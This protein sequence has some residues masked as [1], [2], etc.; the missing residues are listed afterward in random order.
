MGAKEGLPPYEVNRRTLGALLGVGALGMPLKANAAS[1]VLVAT[2]GKTPGPKAAWGVV[3]GNVQD[4]ISKDNLLRFYG[5]LG[6][7]IR[8]TPE[9]AIMTGKFPPGVAPDISSCEGLLLNYKASNILKAKPIGASG[10]ETGEEIT[11]TVDEY[12]GWYV[13]LGTRKGKFGGFGFG[14]KAKITP[15]LNEYGAVKVPF[16]EFT[17]GW[18]DLNFPGKTCQES[19]ENCLSAEILKDIKQIAFWAT[20]EGVYSLSVKDIS[21]YGCTAAPQLATFDGASDINL[22]PVSAVTALGLLAFVLVRIR[23]RRIVASPALLG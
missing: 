21:A 12:K 17:N 4:P 16:K 13:S 14:Y 5:S 10:K 8:G 15:P 3:R 11:K 9:T 6:T 2:F 22:L 18:E 23:G 7:S 19:P 20:G 1:D